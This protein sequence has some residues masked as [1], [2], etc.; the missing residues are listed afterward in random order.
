MYFSHVKP[1]HDFKKIVSKSGSQHRG[2]RL[3]RK[4]WKQVVSFRVRL[5]L[6][7][8]LLGLGLVVS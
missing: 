7:L 8:G 3:P 4:D 2:I 1:L 6:G 5:G